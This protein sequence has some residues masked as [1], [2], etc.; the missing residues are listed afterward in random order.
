MWAGVAQGG[1]VPPDLFSLYVNDIP[2]PSGHV[3][4]AQ[5]ADDTAL[6]ATSRDPSLLVGYLEAYIGRLDLWVRSWRIAINVS[7][8]TAVLFTKAARRPRQPWP[9]QFCGEP[10]Q[11]V[12]TALYLGVTLNTRLTWSSQA[13]QVRKGAAQWARLPLS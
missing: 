3:E 7:K 9:V 8:S 4:L 5:Y 2:T 10:I 1:I 6:I 12:Q 11:W 13:N